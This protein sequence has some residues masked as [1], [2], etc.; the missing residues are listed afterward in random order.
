MCDTLNISNQ[1]ILNHQHELT[2]EWEH[3]PD[4]LEY[5]TLIIELLKY[6]LQLY[7]VDNLVITK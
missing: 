4:V 3:N 2:I 1:G 5:I 6:V 7:T